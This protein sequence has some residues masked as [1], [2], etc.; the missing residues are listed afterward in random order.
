M[1]T[2]LRWVMVGC[3]FAAGASAAPQIPDEV[4]S[5]VSKSL[6]YLT[7]RAVVW[8]DTMK[9]ASCHHAPMMLWACYEAKKHGFAVDETALTTIHDYLLD[10]D[11][12]AHLF[13]SEDPSPTRDGNHLKPIYALLGL[14]AGPPGWETSAIALRSREHF[15]KMQKEDGSWPPFPSMGRRPIFEGDGVGARMLV[16]ALAGLPGS[17]EDPV[18]VP[19]L[20]KAKT[21]LS[22]PLENPTQQLLALQLMVDAKMGAPRETL[23][24]RVTALLAL[25]RS[26]GSWSQTPDM[27]GDAYATGQSLYALGKAGGRMNDAAVARA[28]G[29]LTHGQQADGS[30]PMISRPM[31]AETPPEFNPSPTKGSTNLEPIA[32]AGT[33]WAVLGILAVL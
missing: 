29:F 17:S 2:L 1:M 16:L 10:K 9:C 23:D 27:A 5:T 12:A 26:D 24:A 30:W 19:M 22:I 20:T 28:V 32:Y 6:G 4:S 15:A 13:P 25:Q 7:T 31:P 33:A 11:D 21:W 3:C 14:E 18:I 8:K